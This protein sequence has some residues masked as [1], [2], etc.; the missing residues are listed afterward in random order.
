M[1]VKS[2]LVW[3]GGKAALVSK[4]LH[5]L[6]DHDTYVEPFGGAAHVIAAKPVGKIDVY[7]DILNDVV[8]FM[9]IATQRKDELVETCCSLPYSR[10]L[11]IQYQEELF[12]QRRLGGG[13]NDFDRAVRFFYVNRLGANGGG[14]NHK[15]G[16][17]CSYH[18]NTPLSY[19][20][21][22]ERI[23]Q[24]AERM[25][26]VIIE[27]RDFREIIKGYDSPRTA[28]YVDPPYVGTEYRYVGNFKENEHRE[29]AKILHNVNGKVM[30]SYYDHPLIDELYDDQWYRLEVQ[31]SK[32]AVFA[33]CTGQKK[34]QDTELILTNYEIGQITIDELIPV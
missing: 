34:P 32:S 12:S 22:C 2:P 24:F 6:P 11:F 30:L 5:L 9:V 21:A 19:Q 26:W 10:S 7:N 3:F 15:S 27:C 31:V 14:L 13:M 8:N 25:R 4:I 18:K 33:G 17:K 1:S 16:F 23:N 20:N 29:L 28:F